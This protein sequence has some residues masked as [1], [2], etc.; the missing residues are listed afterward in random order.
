MNDYR[1]IIDDFFKPLS[2]ESVGRR[3][4]AYTARKFEMLNLFGKEGK[5]LRNVYIPK[6]DGGTTEIDLLYISVKGIFV[7]ESKNY[8]GYI[9]GNE[10]SRN[11]TVTLYGGKDFL[12]RKKVEKHQF[13]NPIMQNRTHIKY[14]KKLVGDDIQMISL[15]VFSKRCELK[16]VNISSSDLIV[17][18]RD[19]LPAE[20]RRVWNKYPD[21]LDT[22]K[23]ENL[24]VKLQALTD[25]DKE[26]KE[27]H[28]QKI[29]DRFNSTEICPVC[30]GKLVLRT[31]K[32][33]ANAGKQFYGCSNFPKCRY[34][35]KI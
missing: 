24:C 22:E 32:T 1:S 5:V 6:P 15:I 34:V 18:N 11:W 9:F 20:I 4:E 14:L 8:S 12:G 2:P 7:I 33:G 29:K 30:G 10:D 27:L 35:K 13:Y 25:V 3:G 31:A 19:R 17:C 21:T 28:V 26:Q 23:I 16:S